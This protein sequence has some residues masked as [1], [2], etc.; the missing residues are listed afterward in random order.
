MRIH[1]LVSSRLPSSP[2]VAL[3]TRLR[4]R[5]SEHVAV[6]VKEEESVRGIGT[7]AALLT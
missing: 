5:P 6:V 7:A 4:R 2:P 3:G 1:L